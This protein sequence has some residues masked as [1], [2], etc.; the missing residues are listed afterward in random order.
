MKARWCLEITPEVYR[1]LYLGKAGTLEPQLFSALS[2]P[3]PELGPPQSAPHTSRVGG[4]KWSGCIVRMRLWLRLPHSCHCLLSI[5]SAFRTSPGA[6][7]LCI[8]ALAPRCSLAVWTR[9]GYAYIGLGWGVAAL[10]TVGGINQSTARH[11]RRATKPLCCH[12]GGGGGGTR[13]WYLIVCLWRRLLASRHCS[14]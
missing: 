13:P 9:Q 1:H 8:P 3:P 10:L 12:G 4:F 14:F 7:G 6:I 2:K 11:L 5:V